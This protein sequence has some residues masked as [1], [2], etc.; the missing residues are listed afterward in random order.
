ML[1]YDLPLANDYYC[2]LLQVDTS[3]N[4]NGLLALHLNTSTL[5]AK[6]AFP[7][8]TMGAVCIATVDVSH[9]RVTSALPSKSSLP[10]TTIQAHK[11]TLTGLALSPSGRLLATASESGTLIRVFEVATCNRLHTLRQGYSSST[12]RALSFSKTES[13]I[14][15]IVDTTLFVFN[16]GDV[17]GQHVKTENKSEADGGL[18][19]NFAERY[20]VEESSVFYT[21]KSRLPGDAVAA[22]GAVGGSTLALR[23]MSHLPV[24]AETM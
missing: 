2:A 21:A 8:H 23:P 4:P 5:R 17:T 13:R 15:A 7:A 11:G 22:F 3:E 24:I 19:R 6:V 20:L 16:L 1:L 9:A 10:Q 18:L 12:I 14:C